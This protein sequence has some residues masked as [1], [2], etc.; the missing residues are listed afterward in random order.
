MQDRNPRAFVFTATGGDYFRIW[1][2]NLL[3]SIVTIGFYSPWA[4]VRRLR[5]FYGN[6]LVD[7]SPFD[8][9]GSPI[10][11]LKGR[12]IGIVLLL[13]YSQTARFSLTL[14]LVVVA[15]VIVLFPWLLWKSLRFRLANSSWRGI[16]FGFDG[17]VAEAYLTFIPVILM[18]LGPAIAL[19]LSQ[20]LM[21]TG[22]PEQLPVPYL[23]ASGAV[24]VLAPWF[25]FRLRA[26]QHRH[27][28]LGATRFAFDGTVGGAYWIAFLSFLL[29]LGFALVAALAGG[30]VGAAAYYG[31]RGLL[32]RN[33]GFVPGI[34]AVVVG[35]VVLLSWSSQ[36]MALIQNYV[37]SHSTLGDARFT[38]RV[39]R[40]RLWWIQAVNI[41]LTFATLG[42]FWP[43]AVVRS[44]RYRIE[45]M[46]WDG[47]SGVI[48]A[49][50]TDRVGAAGEESADLFG[51]DLA[52]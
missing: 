2:V 18:V 19:I 30:L 39:G 1:I 13:A 44:M 25:Y 36:P 21:L 37:W 15:G 33:V 6:T 17:T 4:K 9:H 48:E 51:L 20:H 28:R 32:G 7:G 22:E 38:S 45:Q 5:Y 41:G 16:R 49:G 47:D 26:Y 23:V 52:L 27:A 29:I 50:A 46:A 3:L 43:F 34:F 8:F 12:I 24:L 10:A 40:V 31:S 35:Y 11:L 42:F 14:W